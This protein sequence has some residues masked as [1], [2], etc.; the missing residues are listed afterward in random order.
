M[1]YTVDAVIKAMELLFLVAE[2]P[3]LG[4][5][6]IARRSG[7]TKARAFR[8]LGT[9]EESGLVRRQD[10]FATYELGH[11]VLFLGAAAQEQISLVRIAK[12]LLEELGQQCSESVLVR[13]R[14]GLETVCVAWRDASHAIRIHNQ[15]GDRRPLY[16]G[17]SGKLLLAYAPDEIQDVVLKGK[18]EQFTP[19][20][21]TKRGPLEKELEKIRKDGYSISSGEKLADTVAVAA[22]ILDAQGTVIASLSMTA[23]SSRVS[24]S[25][26]SKYVKLVT[27]SAR[28][29]SAKLGYIEK[30]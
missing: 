25:D 14:D 4:V 3:G 29:F 11:R 21:I 26:L 17:A 22:P 7:N 1:S 10:P 2:D 27:A 15:F 16:S 18:R 6:E 23:P 28:K 20:T 24:K 9:L 8:L 5:T 19:N 30:S 12:P 13:I